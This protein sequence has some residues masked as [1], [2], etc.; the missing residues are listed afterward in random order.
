M[1]VKEITEDQAKKIRKL[2]HHA[3]LDR[4]VTKRQATY[5]ITR[6]NR[7]NKYCKNY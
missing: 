7:A 4:I 5:Y 1:N 3:K 6:K 2:S